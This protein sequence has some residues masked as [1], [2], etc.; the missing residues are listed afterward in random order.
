MIF[1]YEIKEKSVKNKYEGILYLREYGCQAVLML[2]RI[3]KHF[4]II[5]SIVLALTLLLA[6]LK[7]AIVSYFLFNILRILDL[8]K[9]LYQQYRKHCTVGRFVHPP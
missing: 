3:S 2:Q 7:P 6:K 5:F 8:R 4:L 1:L 9:C